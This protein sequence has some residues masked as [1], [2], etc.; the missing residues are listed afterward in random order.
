MNSNLNAWYNVMPWGHD[1]DYNIDCDRDNLLCL[2][3][4][5]ARQ[6]IIDQECFCPGP[7]VAKKPFRKLRQNYPN[8]PKLR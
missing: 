3:V 7:F 6:L 5:M 8:Y 2:E 4:D 1:S